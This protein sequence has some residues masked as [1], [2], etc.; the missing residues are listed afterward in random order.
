MECHAQV[1]K[2][3]AKL[4]TPCL[5]VFM[6]CPPSLLERQPSFDTVLRAIPRNKMQI[7]Y[8]MI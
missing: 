8:P 1:F 5:L 7:P 2:A 3:A 4:R 6:Q